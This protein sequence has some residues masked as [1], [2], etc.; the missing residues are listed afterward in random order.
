VGGRA[1]RRKGYEGEREVMRSLEGLP[2]CRGERTSQQQAGDSSVPDVR[3]TFASGLTLAIEAKLRARGYSQIYDD[4]WQ[5][6]ESSQGGSDLPVA[7]VRQSSKADQGRRR[8]AVLDWEDFLFLCRW[9]DRY[10]R[11]VRRAADEQLDGYR[12]LG[13]R[14]A[15]AEAERDHFK[16]RLREA[17]EHGLE[18]LARDEKLKDD[19]A[20]VDNC[21]VTAATVGN[22]LVHTVELAAWERIRRVMEGN[23]HD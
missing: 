20:I 22:Y 11:E 1:S 5:A 18:A 6:I 3:A 10:T 21:L 9:H 8:L 14:A 12:E 19:L 23:E 15:R 2:G 4:L 16:A 7:S 17:H 13:E